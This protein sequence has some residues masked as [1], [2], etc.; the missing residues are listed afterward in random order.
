MTKS[1]KKALSVAAAVDRFIL[2]LSAAN[3]SEYTVRDYRHHLRVLVHLLEIQCVEDGKLVSV[4]D[5]RRVTT[6]HLRQVVRVLQTENVEGVPGRRAIL[7][8]LADSSVR[9][10]VLCYK[11]FFSWCYH[12]GLIASNP[13]DDRLELPKVEKKIRPT[14]STQDVQMMLNACDR[15]T[16]DGYRDF[17]LLLLLFDT[18]IRLAE[19][20]A[21]RVED[22]HADYVKVSGKG[23]KQ[24]EVGIHA[25]TSMVLW[26]YIEMHRDPAN[27]RERRV[28]IGRYGA[29]LTRSGIQGLIK[30]IQEKA[31]LGD[32]QVHAHLFRH[33]FAKFYM[34]NGGD[35]FSL[36]RELGHSDIQTTR[37]YLESFTSVQARKEHTKFS[38]VSLIQIKEKTRGRRRKKK[39]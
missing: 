5:L 6:D 25:D 24:R 4:T 16:D 12:E 21:L 10:Y 30:R 31:G 36:S 22:I 32:I 23:R 19:I 3:R 9:A 14:F 26:K 8:H 1:G 2:S 18:G 11:S 29:P 35:L 27:G 38:P 13:A 15:S 17:A 34:E 33:T 39:E 37:I 20:A 7:G 28:F